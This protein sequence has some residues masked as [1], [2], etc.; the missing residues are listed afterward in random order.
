MKKTTEKTINYSIG[1]LGIILSAYF[2]YDSLRERAPTFIVDP[3]VSTII[4]RELV[5]DNPL[6]ILN[7]KGIEITQDVNVLTFYFFN[8]GNESI[9][10]ENILSDL[11]LSLPVNCEI[12]DYKILK[13]SRD[14]SNIKLLKKDSAKN[15]ISIQ[16]KILEKSDGFTGQIIYVGAKEN[17]LVLRGEIEGVR[18]VSTTIKKLNPVLLI[19]LLIISYVII[20]IYF[21]IKFKPRLQ[22]RYKL[23]IVNEKDLAER[24]SFSF[25]Y[26]KYL[27]AITFSFVLI[28]VSSL[29][30][31]KA[32]S[33]W[34][35]PKYRP[36][37]K[38][39]I[40][41]EILP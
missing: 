11:R 14:V 26:A 31:S 19:S 7:S 9:K 6:K 15:S 37:I 10:S 12:L 28:L 1:I 4:D 39:E 35:D 23:V 33:N 2:Y 27:M 8:Q 13:V 16:F 25:T 38:T 17:K 22:K 3:I 5:K 18:Q 29:F 41:I 36:S 32:L 34:F 24:T 30:L 21:I 40:P 20:N